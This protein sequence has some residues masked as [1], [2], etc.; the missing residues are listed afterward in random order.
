MVWEKSTKSHQPHP[1]FSAW[2]KKKVL[3]VVRKV[4]SAVFFQCWEDDFMVISKLGNKFL[5]QPKPP[6]AQA[7]HFW[8]CSGEVIGTN[9]PSSSLEFLNAAEG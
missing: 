7:A 3:G 2:G 5:F 1:D 9:E 6:V 4:T 8:L